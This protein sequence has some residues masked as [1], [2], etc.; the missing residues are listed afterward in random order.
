MSTRDHLKTLTS[1]T[2]FQSFSFWLNEGFTV[3]TERKIVGRLS[4]EGE[5]ERHFEA[6]GGWKDLKYAVSA[7]QGC[8]L[9]SVEALLHPPHF[10]GR[11]HFGRQQ[12]PDLFGCK[13]DR[14]RS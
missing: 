1:A 14:G 3:F 12:P 4:K 6:I 2:F 11:R 7:Y 10:A 13:S 5:A 8:H 9:M